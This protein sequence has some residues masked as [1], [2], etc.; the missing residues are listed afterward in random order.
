MEVEDCRLNWNSRQLRNKRWPQLARVTPLTAAN[1]TVK[2]DIFMMDDTDDSSAQQALLAKLQEIKNE[3]NGIAQKI[4]ELDQERHEHSLVLETLTKLDGGRKCYR[5]GHASCMSSCIPL[6]SVPFLPAWWIS[7]PP[8][9][10]A[11]L[12]HSTFLLLL[13]SVMPAG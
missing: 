2:S 8:G 11:F 5:S 13:T 1:R 12:T 3:A 9:E 4:S 7:I 10:W 6:A